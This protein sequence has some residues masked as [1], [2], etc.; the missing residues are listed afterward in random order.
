MSNEI[1]RCIN[2]ERSFIEMHACRDVFILPLEDRDQG[3]GNQDGV[4]PMHSLVESG[5]AELQ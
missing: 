2:A 1:Q 4:A 3:E 5:M